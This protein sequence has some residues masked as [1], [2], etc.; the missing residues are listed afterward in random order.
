MTACEELILFF[1]HT[2]FKTNFQGQSGAR[3][4][5][6]V[7]QNRAAEKAREHGFPIVAAEYRV[8]QAFAAEK[9]RE[10]RRVCRD[11]PVFFVT[12]VL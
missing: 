11:V 12:F 8:R 10:R 5:R 3:R 4:K 7:R 6:E 9:A 2:T 1:Y